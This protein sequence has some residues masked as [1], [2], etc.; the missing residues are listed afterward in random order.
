LAQFA[1]H[2]RVGALGKHPYPG[3]KTFSS[4]NL[5]GGTMIN[6]LFGQESRTNFMPACGWQKLHRG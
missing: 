2:L 3:V 1:E 6:A 4:S 5:A